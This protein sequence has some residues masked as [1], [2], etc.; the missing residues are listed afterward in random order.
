MKCYPKALENYNLIKENIDK[1]THE[2]LIF[3]NL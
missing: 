1:H 2:S 3:E